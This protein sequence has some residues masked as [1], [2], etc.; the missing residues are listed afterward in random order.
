MRKR[1]RYYAYYRLRGWLM[2]PPVLFCLS[3]YWH[4][5]EHASLVWPLGLVLFASGLLLRIWAQMHIHYRLKLKMR[6]TT[7]APYRFA[8]NPIYVANTM[9]IAS[10]AVL[11]ELIWFLLPIVLYCAAVYTLVIRFEEAGLLSK[12]GES[13]AQYQRLVPRWFPSLRRNVL[14]S[15]PGDGRKLV[16]PFLRASILAEIHCVALLLLPIVKELPWVPEPFFSSGHVRCT[17]AASFKAKRVDNTSIHENSL[18]PQERVGS[19]RAARDHASPR[20]GGQNLQ[21]G[22]ELPDPAL[23]P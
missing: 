19:E 8:R 1:E 16:F 17:H 5:V 14:N 15:D 11:S 4:E 3:C 13:Y 2:V 18:G 6:L 9:L 22:R 12:Y 20:A 10:I 23:E 21:P 7:T